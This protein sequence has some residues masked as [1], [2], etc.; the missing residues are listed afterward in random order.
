[1]DPNLVIR[2]ASVTDFDAWLPLW[3]GY[4]AFYQTNIADAVTTKTWERFLDPA[5]PMH[6][7]LAELNGKV[8]GI[9]HYIVHRSCWTTGDY[10]YLQ[11]L[12]VESSVRGQGIGKVLIEY[13]YTKARELNASRVWWLTHQSNTDA[14]ALYD[15][16]ADKSGFIQYRKIL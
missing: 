12:L 16:I 3:R 1:M 15:Q 2:P 6:C 7:A 10:V 8:V 11:D 14:M 13:V 5:E 4:Q 9:V